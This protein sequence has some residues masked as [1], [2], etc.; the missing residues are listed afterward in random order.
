[1]WLVEAGIFPTVSV[2]FL[3]KGH[4]ACSQMFNLLK[5][6]Y[7]KSN[8]ETLEEMVSI[9]NRNQYVDVEQVGPKEFFD[10]HSILDKYYRKLASGETNRTH[11]FTIS[12]DRGPTILYK[13]D[14][15][16]SQERK[17]NL[18]PT[19]RNT[20]CVFL[21]PEEGLLWIKDMLAELESLDPPV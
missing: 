2:V 3:V 11:V 21:E 7:R 17:D 6:D 1:M 10:F 13:K 19:K 18:L 12:R 16:T 14:H 4:N 8:I 5:F 15:N 9:L 20:K